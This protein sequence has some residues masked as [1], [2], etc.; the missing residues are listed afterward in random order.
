MGRASLPPFT[1]EES[2]FCSDHHDL[3]RKGH[4]AGWNYEVES[5]TMFIASA[6]MSYTW[7]ECMLKK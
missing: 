5:D 7:I 3:K 2:K 1:T 6:W 4:S